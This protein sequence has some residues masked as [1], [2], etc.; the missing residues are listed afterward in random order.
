MNLKILGILP[1]SI[2][3]RL[4]ISSIFDGF[5]QNVCSR[6]STKLSN[7]LNYFKKISNILPMICPYNICNCDGMLK[8]F[9]EKQC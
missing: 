6:K 3:G 8:I 2:G 5:V 1:H 7:D 4:T 9:K